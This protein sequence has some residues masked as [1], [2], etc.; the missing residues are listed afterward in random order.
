MIELKNQALRIDVPIKHTHRAV[1]LVY[2]WSRRVAY[3]CYS[4][5]MDEMT[6]SV[7]LHTDPIVITVSD[8]MRE[9]FRE[10]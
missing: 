7:K 9:R 1:N 3:D 6:A 8:E 5:E 2:E 10:P 4:A